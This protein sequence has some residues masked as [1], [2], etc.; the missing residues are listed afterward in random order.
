MGMTAAD[1]VTSAPSVWGATNAASAAVV[2]PLATLVAVPLALVVS[3]PAQM[4]HAADRY[5]GVAGRIRTAS[6]E[7]TQAVTRHASADKWS[8]KGKNAFVANR[9]K[10][11]QATLEQAALMYENCGSTLRGC[12]IG[13]TAAGLSSAVIGS[14][15]LGYVATLLAAAAVP[16]VNATATYVANERMVEALEVVRGLI[17]GLAK[18][19]GL[20]GSI[21][22]ALTARFGGLRVAL[23]VLAGGGGAL[24]G[25]HIGA[26]DVPAFDATRTTLHWPQQVTPGSAAP[27]G[28]HAPSAADENAI[29]S[30][31]PASIKALGKDLD[32]GAAK[33]LA[34]AYDEACG[35][36][37]GYPGFGVVGLA[38]G[39]AHSRMRDHA[40]RQLAACRDTPGTWLPG[41]RSTADN[42]V[43]A[44]QASADAAR[45]GR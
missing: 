20:A 33:T 14:A 8:E 12:A 32:T 31:E 9:V 13:Y 45:H 35:N 30:I 16:G 11:Y 4:W 43:W 36:E 1:V 23:P 29:R 2:Y 26:K 25:Y 18:V 6:T 27:A 42:W 34:G 41:L 17:R 19:N 24:G 39:H 38:V 5:D 15:M 44:E 10:P 40:A 37:V 28:Y 21:I 3:D 7:I 22:E